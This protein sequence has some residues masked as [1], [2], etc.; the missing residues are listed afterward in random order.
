MAIPSAT[1]K[2]KVGGQEYLD[3]ATGDGLVDACYKAISRITKTTSTLTRYSVKAITGGT[4]A[5]GEVSCLIEDEGVSVSGQGTHT[6]I[7]MASA[8]AYI[9]ALNK[10]EVRKRKGKRIAGQGP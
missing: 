8:L 5:V 9:N 1:V 4:D 10:S 6:D 7:I 3:H 2:V